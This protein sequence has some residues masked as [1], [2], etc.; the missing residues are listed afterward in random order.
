MKRTTNLQPTL[1][2]SIFWRINHPVTVLLKGT[3]YNM[4]QQAWIEV[5][6]K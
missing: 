5:I 1:P 3:F 4:A 2:L 6:I